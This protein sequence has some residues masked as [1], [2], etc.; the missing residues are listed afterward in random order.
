MHNLLAIAEFGRRRPRFGA[1]DSDDVYG[2][3]DGAHGTGVDRFG[4]D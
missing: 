2:F 1:L 4:V 3:C